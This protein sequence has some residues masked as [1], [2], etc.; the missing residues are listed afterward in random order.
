MLLALLLA[1][2]A[3]LAAPEQQA[4]AREPGHGVKDGTGSGG[5]GGGTES[6]EDD[7]Q[8]PLTREERRRQRRARRRLRR[9]RRGSNPFRE[10]VITLRDGSVLR[11]AI[12]SQQEDAWYL[13]IAGGSVLRIE[14]D[15]VDTVF[16][17][18]RYAHPTAHGGQVLARVAAGYEAGVA[19]SENFGTHT[20]LASE[21]ALGW[22]PHNNVELDLALHFGPSERK[23]AAGLRYFVNAQS[24]LK[25]YGMTSF[26]FAGAEDPLG[27]RLASG[28]QFDPSRFWGLYFHHGA[29]AF[30]QG[31]PTTIHLG[32]HLELGAQLRF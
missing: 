17:E 28:F 4:L 12:T 31:D 2:F 18:A 25:S 6:G 13:R 24:A 22:A 7:E 14:P 19:Y 16:R 8:R 20:G 1:T 9:Q 5:E 26:I 32:Y 27:L 11:G 29:T 10:D 3:A 30:G 21:L 15:Q 23:W